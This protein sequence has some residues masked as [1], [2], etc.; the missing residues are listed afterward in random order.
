MQKSIG[1]TLLE[2][3]LAAATAALIAGAFWFLYDGTRP[4]PKKLN[5]REEALAE[6]AA[7][8]AQFDAD[9][10]GLLDWEEALWQTDSHMADTDGDGIS[11]GMEVTARRNPRKAG[12]DDLLDMPLTAAR[13]EEKTSPLKTA[14][15]QGP[16]S[17]Q[18]S[19][20]P[21]ANPTPPSTAETEKTPPPA[22][23]GGTPFGKGEAPDSDS[24]P[25]YAY[26]NGIGALILVASADQEAELAFLNS[27]AGPTRMNEELIK[28]FEKLAKKYDALAEDIASIIP[29]AEAKIVHAEFA[30]AYKNY[31]KAIESIAR[32]PVG[33]YMSYTSASDYSNATLE[34]GKNVVG[35]SDFFSGT[36]VRFTKNA[37]GAVFMFPR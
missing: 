12:P 25:L 2:M 23:D 9:Q 14:R 28:G 15:T 19:V 31:A 33:S 27:A 1:I 21:T 26:G 10:D 35:I 8:P 37:P 20:L 13:R 3:A 29:P 32:T 36:G 4:Q 30:N 34:I 18:T 16:T 11:D 17:P 22:A 7:A 6:E 24:N 5:F